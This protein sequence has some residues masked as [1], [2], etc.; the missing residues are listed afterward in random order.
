MNSMEVS[1]VKSVEA[2]NNYFF[3]M[4]DDLEIKNW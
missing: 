3:S 1:I 4:V 2:F